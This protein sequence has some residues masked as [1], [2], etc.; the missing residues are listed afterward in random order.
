MNYITFRVVATLVA[1]AVA[2]FGLSYACNFLN[3][4]TDIEFVL[5][6]IV[7]VLSTVFPFQLIR[8]VWSIK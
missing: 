1:L 4:S 2:C 7:A 8:T 3:S 5:G 6:L